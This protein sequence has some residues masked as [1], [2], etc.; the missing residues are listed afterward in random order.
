MIQVCLH[1]QT[2]ALA[3]WPKEIKANVYFHDNISTLKASVSTIKVSI[4]KLTIQER[5][6]KDFS[7]I[8]ARFLA[9]CPVNLISFLGHPIGTKKHSKDIE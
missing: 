8:E 9:L 1:L 3:F 5:F 7:L 6:E 2:D 4:F